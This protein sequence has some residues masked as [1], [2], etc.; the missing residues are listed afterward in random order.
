MGQAE[1]R[2]YLKK[3]GNTWVSGAEIVENMPFNSASVYRCLSRIVKQK[4]CYVDSRTEDSRR[5]RY[6]KYRRVK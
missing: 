2:D 5:R 1:V 6:Y 3:R 4:E